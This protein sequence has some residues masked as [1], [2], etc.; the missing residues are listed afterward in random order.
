M[1]RSERLSKSDITVQAHILIH[2]SLQGRT[3]LV[4]GQEGTE[5]KAK[6]HISR[7]VKPVPDEEA[8]VA[9]RY[10]GHFK[11][12]RAYVANAWSAPRVRLTKDLSDAL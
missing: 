3:G 9:A 1:I 7:L 6:A 11:L 10:V 8:L 5:R 4:S 12:V 2:F